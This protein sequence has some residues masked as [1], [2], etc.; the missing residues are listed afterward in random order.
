MNYLAHILL[1]SKNEQTMLGALL[2]DFVKGHVPGKYSPEIEAEILIHRKIDIYTDGHPVIKEARQRID[3]KRRRYSGILLDMFY[4]HML[5]TNW[6]S[7]CTVP[8]HEF[9][10]RFYSALSNNEHIL[11]ANLV[12]LTPR[13]ISQDWLGSY[14]DFSGVE[15]AIH[16]ISK[17]LSKNGNLLCDGLVDLRESYSLLSAGF[18]VFFPELIRFVEHHRAATEK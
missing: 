17:R 15:V 9:I 1:A 3:E 4:D 10:Q 6:S 12:E 14:A 8:L 7:Y 5:A 13:M 11:P 2:G 18:D 16:R